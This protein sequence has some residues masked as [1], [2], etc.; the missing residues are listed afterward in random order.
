MIIMSVIGIIAL[1]LIAGLFIALLIG[2]SGWLIYI[3]LQFRRTVIATESTLASHRDEWATTLNSLRSTLETHRAEISQSIA[4]I[5]G[6]ELSHAVKLFV[7]AVQDQRS[8]AIRI[9]RAASAI[10]RFASEF[11]SERALD[12]TISPITEGIDTATGYASSS[13]GESSFVSRSRTAIDD[14]AVLAQES[15]DVTQA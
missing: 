13:P 7:S 14:A 15:E 9:E 10:G 8:A 6:Q 1:S 3:G 2:A 12:E 5:N 4:K 11:L